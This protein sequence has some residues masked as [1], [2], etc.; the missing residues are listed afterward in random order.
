MLDDTVECGRYEGVEVARDATYGQEGCHFTVEV[1][2][3][4]RDDLVR[5]PIKSERHREWK[6]A[7]GYSICGLVN[8]GN[9]YT[10]AM[11]CCS[12][13]ISPRPAFNAKIKQMHLVM[14]DV[15]VPSRTTNNL[16]TKADLVRSKPQS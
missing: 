16:T 15:R 13:A 10:S 9:G 1:S 5:E 11:L 3:D 8:N 7:H 4:G 14:R 6:L 2:E 12:T